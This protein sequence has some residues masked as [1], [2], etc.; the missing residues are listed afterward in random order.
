MVLAVEY[1]NYSVYR[2]EAS[3]ERI[4]DD[5]QH[6]L[7]FIVHALGVERSDLILMGASLGSTVAVTLAAN[8]PGL[9]M[10]VKTINKVLVSPIE[11]IVRVVEDSVGG[12][13]ASIASFFVG[14]NSFDSKSKADKIQAPVLLLHGENDKIAGQAHSFNLFGSF[15]SPGRFRSELARAIISREHSHC[16]FSVDATLTPMIREFL[17]EN[18]ETFGEEEPLDRKVRLPRCFFA[19]SN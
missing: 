16:D 2:G 13:L 19:P 4:M 10:L 3:E 6:I 7:D 1:P 8:N 9:C 18:T 15:N 11:S 5:A 12:F 17:A 14:S